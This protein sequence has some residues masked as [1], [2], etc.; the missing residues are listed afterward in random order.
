MTLASGDTLE[1]GERLKSP[2]GRFL[3]TMQEDGNLVLYGDG[4]ALWSSGAGGPGARAQMLT[5]GDLGQSPQGSIPKFFSQ[6][7]DF[8]GATLGLPDDGNLSITH[9]G[10]EIWSW[11]TGYAGNRLLPGAQLTA[12]AFLRSADRRLT[13]VMQGDGNL[14]LYRDGPAV[15]SSG[16]SGDGLRAVMQYDGNF[17]APPREHPPVGGQH[18]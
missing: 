17:V 9:A 5:D 7:R 13:M 2:N 14:V 1:P 11:S 4:I 12:G 3:L 8:P 15:W 16:T 10:R 18:L 6:T